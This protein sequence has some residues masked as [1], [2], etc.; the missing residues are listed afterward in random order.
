[1]G[2]V[3]AVL[4]TSG[5]ALNPA[6]SIPKTSSMP[7]SPEQMSRRRFGAL[8]LVT[9]GW[10]AWVY[11]FSAGYLDDPILVLPL[12]LLAWLGLT[13]W[14]L[15]AALRAVRGR[16]VPLWLLAGAALALGLVLFTT[17]VE[18]RLRLWLSETALTSY[19]QSV[20]AGTVDTQSARWVGLCYVRS[21]ETDAG[22]H[23]V[24]THKRFLDRYGI[25]YAPEGPPEQG[26]RR[27]LEHLYGPW[28][29][30][31]SRF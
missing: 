1:M 11:P 18:V 10:L 26:K 13:L 25:A 24:L 7:P 31:I 21:T 2:D 8:A 15:G 23:F 28:Y 9:W 29:T 16:Q 30:C 14:W 4:R 3:S 17:E 22:A 19:V 27:V 12:A 5:I 6:T 20:E